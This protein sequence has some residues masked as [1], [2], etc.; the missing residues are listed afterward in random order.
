MTPNGALAHELD[1]AERALEGGDAAHA[2]QHVAWCLETAPNDA[3]VVRLL[4]AILDAKPPLLERARAAV[5]AASKLAWAFPDEGYAATFAARARA[6]FRNG[7]HAEALRLLIP[8]AAARPLAGFVAWV[9]AVVDAADPRTLSDIAHAF[10]DITRRTIGILHLRAAERA[11]VQPWADIFATVARGGGHPN[12]CLGASGLLRRVGR[13]EEA[14]AIAE[15]GAK[16]AGTAAPL[17]YTQRALAER[18]LGR[19]DDAERTFHLGVGDDPTL[20]AT[21]LFRVRFERGDAEGALA[22]DTSDAEALPLAEVLRRRLGRP[23]VHPDLLDVFPDDDVTPDD[24]RRW[25]LGDGS[26]LVPAEACTEAYETSRGRE[27]GI[28]QIASSNL[29]PPS[30]LLTLALHATASGDVADLA[31]T[32][33]RTPTPHPAKPLREGGLDLWDTDGS[34]PRRAVSPPPPEVSALLFEVFAPFAATSVLQKRLLARRDRLDPLSP[35]DLAAAFVHPPGRAPE[36]VRADQ[37][38]FA[39]Q[40]TVA[41]ALAHQRLDQ[42]WLASVRRESLRRVLHGAPDWTLAAGVLALR[43]AALDDP[44][45]HEEAVQWVREL[46]DAVPDVGS[47]F[48]AHAVQTFVDA[49]PGTGEL[50]LE[51]FRP[52]LDD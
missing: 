21:E 10:P 37:Y 39:W 51:P 34:L 5:G 31:Y 23:P 1:C 16:G 47:C 50:E 6:H 27:N 20:L 45:A 29:E 44:A 11:F 15:L 42:S 14:I 36:G 13:T 32:T 9:R 22:L 26:P 12:V 52:W 33:D 2:A 49:V 7:S 30:A 3:R 4:D 19:Y 17:L 48:L 38:V 43:E 24:V 40:R 35:V 28:V 46:R 8:L 25:S 41:L 18:A